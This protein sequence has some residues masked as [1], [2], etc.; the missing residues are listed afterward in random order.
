VKEGDNDQF[1]LVRCLASDTDD[2]RHMLQLGN[3]DQEPQEG[4]DLRLPR[5]GR[6]NHR[7]LDDRSRHPR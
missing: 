5:L 6:R 4:K 7:P 3:E 2:L 1:H